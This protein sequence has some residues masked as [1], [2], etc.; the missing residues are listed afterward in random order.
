MHF[1]GNSDI[2]DHYVSYLSAKQKKKGSNARIFG[3]IG[4]PGR[5]P[6]IGRAPTEGTKTV[7]RQKSQLKTDLVGELLRCGS[8]PVWSVYR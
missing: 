2:V 6:R 8:L 3:A 7:D 4:N 5:A 1:L